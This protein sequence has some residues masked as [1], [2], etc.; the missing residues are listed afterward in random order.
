MNLR[1]ETPFRRQSSYTVG[2]GSVA[3]GRRSVLLFEVVIAVRIGMGLE[4][5]KIASISQ[6]RGSVFIAVF[7][8]RMNGQ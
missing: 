6:M 2:R 3:V 1:R 7:H 4:V 8:Y 5:K